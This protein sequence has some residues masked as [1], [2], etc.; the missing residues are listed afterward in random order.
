M[1]LLLFLFLGWGRKCRLK[2]VSFSKLFVGDTYIWPGKEFFFSTLERVVYKNIQN[3]PL[4][5]IHNV[6]EIVPSGSFFQY[7]HKI[8]RRIIT[9]YNLFCLGT[10][11]CLLYW[12]KGFVNSISRTF[13]CHLKNGTLSAGEACVNEQAKIK[14]TRTIYPEK[15]I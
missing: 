6:S 9:S 5:E 10:Y 14:V 1:L 7:V 15:W 8:F 4:D 11:F 12:F 2:A 3:I 13:Q